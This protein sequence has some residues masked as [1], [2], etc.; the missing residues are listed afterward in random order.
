MVLRTE[1]GVLLLDNYVATLQYTPTGTGSYKA[2]YGRI[3][4]ANPN[5]TSTELESHI[6]TGEL[7]GLIE[8]Y[9]REAAER[10][11]R[12]EGGEGGAGAG[13]GG[14]L[15]V[16]VFRLAGGHVFVPWAD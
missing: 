2:D 9:S 10:S 4:A 13:D 7:R 16:V 12:G 5:G 6:M 14:G 15:S 11:D 8:L 3:T 1:D